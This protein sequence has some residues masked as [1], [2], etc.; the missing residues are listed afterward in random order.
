VLNA[1]D[2][3]GEVTALFGLLAVE[4]QKAGHVGLKTTLA[5]IFFLIALVFVYRS[6][7]G[8][9]ISRRTIVEHTRRP[10][11]RRRQSFASLNFSG[12]LGDF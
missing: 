9:R 3:I 1:T 2:I 10:L 8:M 11:Q 12:A 4:M 6:F 5:S 7:Y